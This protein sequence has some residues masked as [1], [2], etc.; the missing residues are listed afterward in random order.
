MARTKQASKRNRRSVRINEWG[1]GGCLTAKHL[2]ESP[3]LSRRGG[4]LGR[5]LVDILRFRTGKC[6]T[7]SSRRKSRLGVRMPRL[8]MRRAAGEVLGLR[9][10]W[11][12][13]LGLLLVLGPLWLVLDH[14]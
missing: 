8:P 12:L 3:N 7:T 4:N 11:R 14:T 9:R 10:L 2:S 5:E 13:R 6:R 1:G